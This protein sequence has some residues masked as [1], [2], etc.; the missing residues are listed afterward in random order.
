[1]TGFYVYFYYGENEELLYVGQSIDVGRRWK[2]HTEYWKSEVCK[3]GVREYPDDASMDIF[4]Y[5]YI[6]RLSPKYNIARLHRGATTFDIPDST[7]LNIY[8]IEDFLKK[9]TSYQPDPREERYFSFEEELAF[10]GKII[11][12][13]IE[14]DLFDTKWW[15]YDL[16]KI[17]FRYGNIYLS[18]YPFLFNTCSKNT[19]F[20]TSN[21][22]IEALYNIMNVVPVS[23]EPKI[24]IKG[25]DDDPIIKTAKTACNIN[26]LFVAVT[27][28]HH[29]TG[30]ENLACSF[31]LNIFDS[32]TTYDRKENITTIDIDFGESSHRSKCLKVL[33]TNH[34]IISL[35]EILPTS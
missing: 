24:T 15:K 31:P 14:V 29:R 18:T 17:I 30:C 12:D 7:T 2:E 4:E 6:T 3:I 21:L 9:Y 11:V 27:H 32:I 13:A 22:R 33:D 34:F 26:P 20:K 35:P 10:K 5:Y 23:L 28:K 19:S 8:S 25:K 1:M 16:D